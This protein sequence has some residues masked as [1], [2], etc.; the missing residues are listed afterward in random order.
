MQRLPLVAAIVP[1]MAN[2]AFA[3]TAEQLAAEQ[4]EAIQ[5]HQAQG[6]VQSLPAAPGGVPPAAPV[7]AASGSS[8]FCI[9]VDTVSITG[10]SL[11]HP[12]RLSEAVSVF[13]G[14]CLGLAEMNSVL[15][16]VTFAYVDRGYITARAYLP[17]QDLSDGTLDVVVV[18][19]HLEAIVI[20]GG[21]DGLPGQ[22]ATA[23]PGMVGKPLNLR[24]MEQGLEL[25]ERLQSVNVAM[26]ITA[27]SETG[28][29]VL[30]VNLRAGRP[31]HASVGFDNL[32][33]PSTGKFQTLLSFGYDDLLDLNDSLSLSYQRSMAGSPLAFSDDR[34]N[35]DA[36]TA[37]LEI[38]YGYWTFGL[39][40]SFNFHRSEIFGQLGA[41]ETSGKSR[42][43]SL[44]AAHILH[45]DQTSKT[46]LTGTLT[47]K[48]TQSFVM[49]TLVGVSSR[50]LSI[51]ALELSH[52]R[53]LWGGQATASLG[54]DRGL[55]IWGAFDDDTAPDGSPKGQF[56]R[57]G[58]SLGFARSFEAGGRSLSYDGRL[59]A[60]WSDDLLFGSEQM[61]LGGHA[62][63][64]GV[65]SA[66][67]SGNRAVTLRNE[68]ST[69]LPEL[70]DARLASLFGRFEP[71]MAFD[72][73]HVWGEPVHDIVGGTLSGVAIGVRN[74]GGKVVLD[75][76]YAKLT[77]APGHLS[78]VKARPGV[79]MAS[80]T[81]PL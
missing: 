38:P 24:D 33:S 46:S 36:L 35:G 69:A 54:F 20:N 17:E 49:G 55:D 43:I 68:L 22:R 14:K 74:R 65:E 26:E 42:S 18:E 32:G 7:P 79:I 66:V 28:A 6:Q 80:L 12:S 47:W 37:N 10:V 40:G 67:L 39:K 25:M 52:S 21:R 64:R 53:R 77:S 45:R 30:N 72:A 75:L 81:V 5:R 44:S 11:V 58:L 4:A 8:D 19:G 57:Y 70:R 73:G 2:A 1:F 34:P 56:G 13:E 59:S 3:Q 31:W 41:T 27:G 9:D 16:A 61:S 51:A 60:Q 78:G 23:F 15:E 29:S 48:D 71:Y 76:S 62:S 63:I 50:S